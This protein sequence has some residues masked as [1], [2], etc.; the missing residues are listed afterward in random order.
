MGKISPLMHECFINMLMGGHC[1]INCKVS[2][3]LR[4][5]LRPCSLRRQSHGLWTIDHPIFQTSLPQGT[6][7]LLLTRESLSGD[8]RG[9]ENFKHQTSNLPPP[10]EHKKLIISNINLLSA[11]CPPLVWDLSAAKKGKQLIFSDLHFIVK[12]TPPTIT[13]WLIIIAAILLICLIWFYFEQRI[14][15][16]M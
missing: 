1:H 3:R 10:K 4:L 6:R 11:F 14:E 15:E 13:F 8:S 9:K 16:V 7:R 12:Q 5:F 2:V